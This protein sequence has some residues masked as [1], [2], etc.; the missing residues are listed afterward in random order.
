MTRQGGAGTRPD[1]QTNVARLVAVTA[2]LLAA[3]ACA[4]GGDGSAVPQA[5][6]EFDSESGEVGAEPA[7]AAESAEV[8]AEPA[9]T[10]ESGEVGAPAE[11]EDQAPGESPADDGPAEPV[12]DEAP[13]PPDGFRAV[14]V[15]HSHSC[16]VRYDGAV[17]C[18]GDSRGQNETPDVRLDA[19]T[20]GSW[21]TCG[22]RIDGGIQ[23]WG[24]NGFGQASPPSGRFQSVIAGDNYTCGLRADSTVG[25]W[26]ENS[27]GQTD[28]PGDGFIM[29]AADSWHSC[30]VR[31]DST[32]AC[33]GYNDS[34][35]AD[36]PVGLFQ[37]VTVDG[38]HS[39][40]VRTDGT[41]ACWGDNSRGQTD[42][43]DGEFSAVALGSWH[44]CGL[45]SDASIV[46]W[47]DNGNGQTDAPT[48]QFDAV[49]AG[50]WF[51][52]GLRTDGTVACW[53]HDRYGQSDA[54]GGR[55]ESVSAGDSYACGLRPDSSAV[56]WGLSVQAPPRSFSDPVHSSP[57]APGECR[58]RGT[59]GRLTA[60]FPLPPWA[61]P[62]VG[63]VR[64]AALFVDFADAPALHSTRREAELGLA[65]IE[66]YVE[67]ASHGRLDVEFVP[68]HR[69]L[70]ARYNH[71][72]YL[73]AGALRGYSVGGGVDAEA[74]RLADPEFDFSGVDMV[75][76]VMPSSH[77]YGGGAGGTVATDEGLRSATL[78]INTHPWAAPVDPFDWGST[79][80]HEFAHSLGLL[81]MYSYYQAQDERPDPGEG[82]TW[83][84]ARFGLMRLEPYFL[85]PAEDPPLAHVWHL[86]DGQTDTSY[87]STV[88][89]MEMLA[90]SR[91]QL[92]WLDASQ[93]RCMTE[94][95]ATVSLRPVAD[96][97]DGTAMAVVPLSETEVI[98]IESRR[99]IGLDAD[100]R[101]QFPDGI[102]ATFPA[103][104]SEGVLVYTVDAA[105]HTGALPVEV[106]GSDGNG[107]FSDYPVLVEG[108]SVAVGGYTVSFVS[109]DAAAHTVT[110]SKT[111]E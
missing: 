89:A 78:R 94:S 71:D 58:P 93:V 68:L 87:V 37:S 54:P 105:K 39:C 108:Q 111:G 79:G 11:I 23:C 35:Q 75:M 44:S 5:A 30:G 4:N 24:Y 106:A 1:A 47:G 27:Y 13:L 33:W 29:V 42:A 51:S 59:P 52:C 53:G 72:R 73:S 102:Y 92:G 66:E 86:P 107:W 83:V 56:C 80:A 6:E 7:G 31:T 98:V 95:E 49:T 2:L 103:L 70:R 8:G 45:R 90:W 109:A 50:D 16:G 99:K 22:L 12:E 101:P 15:G 97:G 91:W 34:G 41:V 110:V 104:A 40:G 21:H 25:C 26:G 62:S 36:A 85:A 61:A 3:S 100:R 76:V 96:P 14:D 69:W 63:T 84:Q 32:V 65:H 88:E 64:V 28:V 48:G 20:A 10:A 81:D 55:F 67:A 74:V 9:E 43:P 57:P 18:W 60:G 46:C 77:F 38:W 17:E 82:Q 19:V